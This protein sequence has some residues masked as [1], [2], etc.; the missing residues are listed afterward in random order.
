[1]IIR[2]NKSTIMKNIFKKFITSILAITFVALFTGT[3]IVFADREWTPPDQTGHAGEFLQTNGSYTL[4]A[5][6]GSGTLTGADN[7]LS[8]SGGTTVELGGTLTKNTSISGD[9]NTY[10]LSLSDLD[11]FSLSSVSSEAT[12]ASGSFTMSETSNASLPIA[13]ALFGT[14]VDGYEMF[15]SDIS[16]G[17]LAGAAYFIDP[18]NSNSLGALTVLNDDTL[19]YTI[20]AVM[21]DNGNGGY[22]YSVNSQNGTDMAQMLLDSGDKVEIEYQDGTLSAVSSLVGESS[23]AYI[24]YGI[25]TIISKVTVDASTVY[26]RYADTSTGLSSVSSLTATSAILS[27]QNTTLS[28]VLQTGLTANGMFFAESGNNYL[29]LDV[30]NDSYAIGDLAGAGNG[31]TF[32]INDSTGT[33][34]FQVSNSIIVTDVNTGSNLISSDITKWEI[35][36]GDIG[37]EVHGVV[38]NLSDVG[39]TFNFR[40]GIIRGTSFHNNTNLPQGDATQQDIRSGTYTPTLTNV[41]NI[42]S[43]TAYTFQWMRVG[44]VVTVSGKVDITNTATGASAL[45]ISLPI[46]SSISNEEECVGSAPGATSGILDDVGWVVGDATNDRAEMRST[47]TTTSSHSHYITFTYQVI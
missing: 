25:G 16:N 38:F 26:S 27:F 10:D 18:N 2:V 20:T 34:Q 35:S 28:S 32:A 7:G 3:G 12:R 30:T 13:S 36:M 5:A 11:A 43:S 23:N 33:A 15:M 37:S 14:T 40:Q 9:S 41:T 31:N 45:G 42:T 22:A 1:M 47:A 4:W 8:V 17:I 19:G 29:Y 24:R 44:N 46:A 39:Y 6:A 21:L